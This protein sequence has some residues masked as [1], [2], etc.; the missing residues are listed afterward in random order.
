MMT[1]IKTKIRRFSP[2]ALVLFAACLAAAQAAALG[3]VPLEIPGG[4]RALR[5]LSDSFTTLRG[6]AARA[7]EER[8]RTAPTDEEELR[9]S[10]LVGKDAAGRLI[11]KTDCRD[12][13]DMLAA[14]A[15]WKSGL[16]EASGA[17]PAV[18]RDGAVCSAKID[19]VTP[20]LIARLHGTSTRHSGPNCWNTALLSARVVLSQRASEAEELRFWTHSPLCREL[21][22]QE[23]RFPGDIISVSGPADSPEMHAFVYIT[24]KLAFA[25]NGFDVQFPYELQSLEWQ[26]HLVALGGDIAPAACRRAVGRPADCNVWANHYRCTPY[27]EYVAGAQVLDK[28]IFL[29][30]DLELTAIESKISAIVTAGVWTEQARLE[31]ESGLRPI[32]E[33]ALGKTAS[34]PGDF[35]WKSLLARIGSFRTQFYVLDK[36][37]KKT[38]GFDSLQTGPDGPMDARLGRLPRT[39]GRR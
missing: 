3:E 1:G 33:L 16:G 25:K 39:L 36:E 14:L 34:S 9:D 11:L 15:E 30:T 35:L 6:Q 32:E 24:D 17:A 38:D 28:E 18:S 20:S 2:A 26:F 31:L 22:P 19:A 27:A 37:L 4:S 7:A 13:P 29:K 23:R 8:A 21:S 5:D 12:M 10:V